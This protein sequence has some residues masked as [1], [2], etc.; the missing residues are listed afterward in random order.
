MIS[1]FGIEHGDEVSKAFPRN[2]MQ[3]F[4]RGRPKPVQSTGPS[5]PQRVVN[6]LNRAGDTPITIKG[7]GRAAGGG[8]Q[9]TGEFLNR[10]PGLTGTALLGGGGAAGYRALQQQP[11]KKKKS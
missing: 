8:A 3:A 1:A 10:H 6:A 9:R 7:V 2:P 11:P 5:G 4:K